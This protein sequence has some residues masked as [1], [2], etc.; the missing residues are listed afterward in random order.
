MVVYHGT[1]KEFSVFEPMKPRGAIG[2]PVGIYFDTDKRVAEEYAMNDDGEID[3]KS[4][5]IQAFVKVIDKTDGLLKQRTER[6]AKH[7]EII[8]FNP[9]QIKLVK[10]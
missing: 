5:V 3:S 10:G 7:T 1:R 4:K 6:G 9:T 2:N 8:A